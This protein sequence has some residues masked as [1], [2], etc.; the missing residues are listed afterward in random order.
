[1]ALNRH[2]QRQDPARQSA[3]RD[4]VRLPKSCTK[5][6]QQ[7]AWGPIKRG[8]RERDNRTV[9]CSNLVAIRKNRKED[10]T[11]IVKYIQNRWRGTVGPQQCSQKT[12]VQC[13][14]SGRPNPSHGYTYRSRTNQSQVRTPKP[15]HYSRHMSR[16]AE[17]ST[18][19]M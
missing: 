5:K 2:Q 19:K 9:G 16:A 6:L 18:K 4:H 3:N 12:I 13:S 17:Q 11:A 15:N 8:D 10:V 1:M 14:N 7:S